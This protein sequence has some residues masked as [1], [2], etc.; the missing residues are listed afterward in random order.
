MDSGVGD[1]S[2]AARPAPQTKGVREAL[3]GL[4]VAGDDHAEALA[5]AL[6]C[7]ALPR[8]AHI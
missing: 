1:A 8:H 5:M 6:M 7:H 2:G 4:A 3:G